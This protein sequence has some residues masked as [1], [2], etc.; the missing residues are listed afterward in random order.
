MIHVD[1]DPSEIGKN[2]VPDLPIVGDAR[3][4][5]E[6]LNKFLLETNPA[7]AEANAAARQAWWRQVRQWQEEHPL[8]PAISVFGDQAAAA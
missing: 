8:A 3:R 7:M 6:K 1:I 5:L 2:R 4:V